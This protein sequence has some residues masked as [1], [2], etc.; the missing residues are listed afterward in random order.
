MPAIGPT[1]R[2][3]N[4]WIGRLPMNCSR[5]VAVAALALTIAGLLS[6][7]MLVADEVTPPEEAALTNAAAPAAGAAPG[8]LI[9][10]NL[11]ARWVYQR[12]WQQRDG[13]PIERSEIVNEVRGVYLFDNAQWYHLGDF[14]WYF[15][16][17]PTSRGIVDA[18]VYEDEESG[19]LVK[20]SQRL[21]FKYPVEAA[22]AYE[23]KPLDKELE[24]PLKV[25]VTG[26]DTEVV[27]PAGKFKCLVYEFRSKGADEMLFLRYS[28]APGVGIVKYEFF[29]EES[30]EREVAEL[31][32]YA[33]SL[34][35]TG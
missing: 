31:K 23:L 11:G 6:A 29:D 7:G 33:L 28:I 9:P 3:H 14:G 20:Q 32:S 1:A 15:W 24:E 26:V 13:Q 25:L 19:A 27:V 10:L 8:E 18:L 5:P 17:Q 22:T 35:K 34:P 4:A 21:Y 12:T 16:V 30:G 2:W